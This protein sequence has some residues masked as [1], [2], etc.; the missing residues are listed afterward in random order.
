MLTQLQ[1]IVLSI[2]FHIQQP[3]TY[4][5][6][7]CLLQRKFDNRSINALIKKGLAQENP[8][9]NGWN[10]GPRYILTEAGKKHATRLGLVYVPGVHN[11]VCTQKT[12][13]KYQENPAGY[14][15]KQGNVFCVDCGQ[16][17][18]VDENTYRYVSIP[19]FV[20]RLN[21]RNCLDG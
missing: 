10:Y 6:A 21:C 19:G 14:N 11:A 13:Q 9:Y 16:S 8:D 4:I 2:L 3:R 1:E 18:M 7:S 12:L 15:W 20:E 17:L 5:E